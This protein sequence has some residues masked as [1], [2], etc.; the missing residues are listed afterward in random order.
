MKGLTLPFTLHPRL[1]PFLLAE[2]GL[3]N[4]CPSI[5]LLSICRDRR[6]WSSGRTGQVKALVSKGCIKGECLVDRV[7]ED[8]WMS[9]DRKSVV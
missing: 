3:T 4:A 5:P 9:Q 6:S 8:R 1:E 7:G 2:Y